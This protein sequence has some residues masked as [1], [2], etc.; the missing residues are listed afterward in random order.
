MLKQRVI[1]ALGLLGVLLPCLFARSPLPFALLTLA[2][3]AAAMWEWARLNQ[4]PSWLAVLGGALAL[5][6]GAWALTA[7]DLLAPVTAATL[8]VGWQWLAV[9]WVVGAALML[10][11]GSRYWSRLW[12]G[13][14][15]V[16]GWVILMAAW[17]ALTRAKVMGVNFLL[18]VLCLVWA[19]DIGAYFGGRAWGRR[20]LAVTIS[21]GKSWEG[22]FSGAAAVLTLAVCWLAAERFWAL[23]SASLYLHLREGGGIAGLV[24][25]LLLLTGMSVAGDLIESLIKRQAGVKDSSGLLP[26]HG[27]VLDRIDA[28]LPVLPLAIALVGLSHG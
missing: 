25:G 14:R 12:R 26:G 23:G 11:R 24:V 6:A 9:C 22:V 21:P 27:G 10:A 2:F 28:L 8:G 4:T 1:T 3:V 15:D 20:K 19:A 13:V 7:T 16:L 17:L 5:A 18:S